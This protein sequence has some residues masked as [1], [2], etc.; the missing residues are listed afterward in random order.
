M[1]LKSAW[2]LFSSFADDATTVE[3]GIKLDSVE[4]GATEEETS[5]S[6]KVPPVGG[7]GGEILSSTIAAADLKI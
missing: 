6:A 2:R 7:I 4:E 5:G 3:V 1:I